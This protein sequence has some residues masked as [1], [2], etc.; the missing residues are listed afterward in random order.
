MSYRSTMSSSSLE[1]PRRQHSEKRSG[2]GRI[3]VI[4]ATIAVAVG[5]L[6]WFLRT[7]GDLPTSDRS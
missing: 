5:W 1:A 6:V 4:L 3:V 7:P 2:L